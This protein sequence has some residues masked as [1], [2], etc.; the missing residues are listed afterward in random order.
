MSPSPSLGPA[1]RQ[2]GFLQRPDCRIYYEVTG[3][4]PALVFAH[5]LGGNH[6]SWWQ[7][8]A[9]FCDRY[10]CISFSHRG[11]FPSDAPAGGPDPADY[12][13]DLTALLA[14]LGVEDVCIIG[15]SMGGWTALDHALAHARSGGARLRAMVLAATSG[16]VDPAQSEAAEAFAAWQAGAA[17]ALAA[18][19]AKGVHPA[20]GTRGAAEQPAA[21]FLYRA[22]DEL[23]AT[24]D[25]EALRGR[26]MRGRT[27]PA[28]ALA[29]LAVPTL[30]LTGA[31]DIV[32]PSPVAPALAAA[33]PVARHVEFAET[34]HS[35]YFERPSA[36]N[37]ALD[38]FLQDF[39]PGRDA[40]A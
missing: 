11:F 27:L 35:A 5:G 21:H 24:L 33:M 9:A 38:D 3:R 32:F 12:A 34:G 30:W 18:G 8:I 26:L 16:P 7:Q 39:F 36:F 22:I 17:P 37:A 25:K 15:Q 29:G 20:L 19:R 2:K 31:E 14:H 23:S 1:P 6:L 10:S 13:G 28:S 40:Q 4:G